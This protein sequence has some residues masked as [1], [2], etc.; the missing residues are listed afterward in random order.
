MRWLLIVGGMA[1]AASL[2]CRATEPKPRDGY[3]GVYQLATVDDS[4]MPVLVHT[5]STFTDSLIVDT[6]HLD[7]D[8][9]GTEVSVTR[10]DSVGVA[11]RDLTSFLA[12]DYFIRNDTLYFQPPCPGTAA[13][14][15]PGPAGWVL[16]DG[17]LRLA[18]EAFLNRTFQQYYD[19][20]TYVPTR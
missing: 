15:M 16:P 3:Q 13:S 10:R 12:G 17:Q 18:M 19:V 20:R 2:S 14:C 1:V 9:H 8:G 6:L 7:G 5:A 11:P 4:T